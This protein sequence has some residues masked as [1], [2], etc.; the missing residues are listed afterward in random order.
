[1][2]D[3]VGRLADADVG[4]IFES[5]FIEQFARAGQRLGAFFLMVLLRLPM[6]S[7]YGSREWVLHVKQMNLQRLLVKRRFPYQQ[8]NCAQAVIRT[9]DRHQYFKHVMSSWLPSPT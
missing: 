6:H 7:A 5:R 9:V 1:M 8:P 4:R 2:G 3:D